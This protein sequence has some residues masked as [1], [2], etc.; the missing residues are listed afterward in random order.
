MAGAS[1]TMRHVQR[2]VVSVPAKVNL[3]LRV[4]GPRADG[5]H[6]L[7]TVFEALDI[8]DDVE[9]RPAQELTLSITGL[10]EDLPTDESNLAIRAAR[11]LQE[12]IGTHLGADIRITKRIPV[13]AG[14]AGGSA[15][16]AG[17]LLALNELWELGLSKDELMRIG[18]QLGSDVPFAFLG[19]LAHGVGRGEKLEPVRAGGMHA[20]VLLT[21]T[22]GLSTPAVFRQ[23]DA[24]FPDA[25]APAGTQV[26]RRALGEASLAAVGDLLVNDLQPAATSLRPE[27]GQ[28]I[29]RIAAAG[30]H[31]ILSGSGPTIAVL[32]E[33][34]RAE[35]LA[36]QL[37]ADFPYAVHVAYG[38][39][40]GAHV[41]QVQ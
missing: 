22:E 12:R 4:G 8:F 17:T 28:E 6:P 36:A 40:A 39:A 10:G 37:R 31:V 18:A 25:G 5:F 15:D 23:F 19:G 11:A 20:W 16:A 2:V 13:A 29:E 24:L 30:H 7:D 41:R 33:P 9:V 27:I 3:A 34:E 1:A 35:E 32:I 26:L 21:R 38:P 14:M